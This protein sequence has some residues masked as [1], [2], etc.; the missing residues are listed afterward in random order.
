[1]VLLCTNVLSQ[2]GEKPAVPLDLVTPGLVFTKLPQQKMRIDSSESASRLELGTLRSGMDYE[3]EV[4]MANGLDKNLRPFKA[5]TS[6]NCLVG[7][8]QNQLIFPGESGSVYLRFRTS[9]KPLRQKSRIEFEAGGFCDID[10]QGEVNPEFVISD[11]SVSCDELNAGRS[12]QLSLEAQYPD[13]ELSSVSVEP[14]VGLVGI[15]DVESSGRTVSF[16]LVKG[17]LLERSTES[18]VLQ[19]RFKTTSNSNHFRSEDFSVAMTTSVVSARPKML[20]IETAFDDGDATL[21]RVVGE[22]NL[23]NTQPGFRLAA[24]SE[25]RLLLG[26][27]KVDVVATVVSWKPQ[28]SSSKCVFE[29]RMPRTE[30]DKFILSREWQSLAIE[31]DS[32]RVDGLKCVFVKGD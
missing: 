32:V 6:C 20:R 5:T 31:S 29:A 22:V 4:L 9:Q 23:Y 19:V 26:R 15:Q 12:V 27:D 13:I 7:T 16:R 11:K 17:H 8:V 3:V 14:L 30:C 1:M 10:V 2:D 24:G 21:Y 25:L 18:E 28:K